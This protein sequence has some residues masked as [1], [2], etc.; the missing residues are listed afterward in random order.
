MWGRYSGIVYG[1]LSVIVMIALFKSMTKALRAYTKKRAFE[2]DNAR[3]FIRYW[4]Y[5]Y[6]FSAT[7]ICVTAFSGEMQ[8]LGITM[9]F[10]GSIMAWMLSAPIRNIAGWIFLIKSKPLQVGDRV[11]ISGVTGDVV[12]ITMNHIILDQVGGTVVGEERSGRGALVP[13]SWV[14]DQVIANYSMKLPSD[15]SS[16]KYLLDEIVARVTYN[17]DWNEAETILRAAAREVTA[18]A[19]EETGEEPYIRAEFFPSGVFMRLRY[20]VAPTDRQRVWSEITRRASQKLE[21]NDRVFYCFNKSDV[22]VNFRPRGL[23]NHNMGQEVGRDN[24]NVS[25]FEM[26]LG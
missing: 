8:A 1:L 10:I 3:I 14:F 13:M 18:D 9:A 15:E 7:A 16:Q 12:D 24:G 20:R 23:H 25:G 2:E 26:G 11:I 19:I 5:G 17:S 21:E 4:Q 6:I 22:L